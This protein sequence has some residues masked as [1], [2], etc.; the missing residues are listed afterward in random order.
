LTKEAVY[1][2]KG[3]DNDLVDNKSF[4][5]PLYEAGQEVITN[6]RLVNERREDAKKGRH[7]DEGSW[8]GEAGYANCLLTLMAEGKVKSTVIDSKKTLPSLYNFAEGS[9]H[10][11]TWIKSQKVFY[12][13][14]NSLEVCK[15][16]LSAAGYEKEIPFTDA[17][18]I[19]ALL[20]PT[21]DNASKDGIPTIFKIESIDPVH[22]VLRITIV[23]SKPD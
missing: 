2:A 10:L 21:A 14:V 9:S 5:S 20:I 8:F 15:V 4:F 19:D 16:L 22:L 12:E 17:L 13:E 3:M 1:A 11:T 6:L 18:Y 7:Y 23:K